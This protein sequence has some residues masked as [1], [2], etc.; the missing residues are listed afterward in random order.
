MEH[1]DSLLREIHKLVKE[2]NTMLHRL[3]RE[4]KRARFWKTL[5]LIIM[6]GLLFG[7]YYL[8]QPF[9]ENLTKAYASIQESFAELQ[10]TKDSL[11]NFGNSLR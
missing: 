1:D 8:V 9:I 2:N 6:A 10:E 5:R 11:S 7:A 3:D 4:A